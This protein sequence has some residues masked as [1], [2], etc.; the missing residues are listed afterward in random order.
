M[1]FTLPVIGWLQVSPKCDL[2]RV[3]QALDK[4][5]NKAFIADTDS[6]TPVL[7]S[8][9]TGHPAFELQDYRHGSVHR[10][11]E[12]SAPIFNYARFFPWVHAVEQVAEAFDMA[13]ENAMN[14]IP[15]RRDGV[16]WTPDALGVVHNENRKGTLEDVEMY[17]RGGLYAEDVMEDDGPD[18]L[19]G[20]GASVRSRNSVTTA[21]PMTA[22]A[23]RPRWSGRSNQVSRW[24]SNVWTRVIVA[25][26]LAL[27]LQWGTTGAAFMIVVRTVLDLCHYTIAEVS[28]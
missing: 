2:D 18:K 16:P 10:D 25:S 20:G 4:A 27:F 14:N 1:C 3:A 9:K 28:S 8:S 21:I 6:P 17:C 12:S 13:S 24:D 5:N 7:S 19:A 11:E 15:V 22:I 26:A 23:R